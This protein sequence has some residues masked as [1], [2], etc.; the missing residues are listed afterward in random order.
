VR[1]DYIQDRS[2]LA[3]QGP[4]AAEV[5]KGLLPA[6]FNLQAMDFMYHTNVKVQGMDA[7]LSRCGYTGED[8]FEISVPSSS[9][10]AL[11]NSLLANK[12][13]LAAGL[14]PRDSLR[15]EAGL[16]LYG[17]EL[18][19]TITPV[20]AVLS[21]LIGKRRKEEG[22]FLG[23]N[24]I[25]SQLKKGPQ[26][27]RVGL[28]VQKGAP[29]RE[30]TEIH[31]NGSKIGVV[32]SGTFSPC[33]KKAISMA[34]VATPYSNLGTMVDVMIRGKASQAEVVKLPFVP[35]RYFKKSD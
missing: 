28:I 32:T 4:K 18:N 10:A 16:C 33:L 30:E 9:V 15:L 1:V 26:R 25:L 17:H 34:Y 12:T 3:L 31:A 13:V 11:W 35:T 20:E 7:W 2:L 8:G 24:I 23:S 29:A 21:W 6:S 27:K 14:G 19:E 22:G 5:L